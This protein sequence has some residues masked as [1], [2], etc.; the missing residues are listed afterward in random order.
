MD[1]GRHDPITKFRTRLYRSYQKEKVVAMTRHTHTHARVANMLSPL[2][3]QSVPHYDY[4][5]T[6]TFCLGW[7]ALVLLCVIF[8]QWFDLWY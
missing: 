4:R 8:V 1:I 6:A 3:T 5:P 2:D 7:V